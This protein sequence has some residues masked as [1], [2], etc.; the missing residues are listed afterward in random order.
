MTK[1]FYPFSYHLKFSFQLKPP[2]VIS[3]AE[4]YLKA[5]VMAPVNRL[6]AL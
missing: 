2:H 5:M 4:T 1:K 3:L 6:I